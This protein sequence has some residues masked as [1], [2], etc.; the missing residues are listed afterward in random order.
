MSIHTA[1]PRP[2]LLQ[3]SDAA[4]PHSC[5]VN[6]RLLWGLRDNGASLEVTLPFKLFPLNS[7]MLYL[8]GIQV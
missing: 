8:H 7:D 6:H 2:R 1:G 4:S 5:P 3:M